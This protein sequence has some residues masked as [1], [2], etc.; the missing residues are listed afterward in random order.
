MLKGTKPASTAGRRGSW[1]FVGA[2]VTALFDAGNQLVANKTNPVAKH[3]R[4]LY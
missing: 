1:Y 2:R 4:V 3:F